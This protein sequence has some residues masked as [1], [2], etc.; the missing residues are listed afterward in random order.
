MFI[1]LNF[2]IIG[3]FFMIVKLKTCFKI[4][5]RVLE[6]NRIQIATLR[7]IARPITHDTVCAACL[8][9]VCHFCTVTPLKRILTVPTSCIRLS[10]VFE[11]PGKQ[12]YDNSL[13]HYEFYSYKRGIQLSVTQLSGDDRMA[14][15]GLS[16]T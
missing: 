4:F 6:S 9:L 15:V 8:T 12:I 13:L 2:I 3:F 7:M 14:N 10:R 1:F 16:H 11:Y 5:I